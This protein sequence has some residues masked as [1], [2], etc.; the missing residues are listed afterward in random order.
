MDEEDLEKWTMGNWEDDIFILI[1]LGVIFGFIDNNAE[2]QE[3]EET[4]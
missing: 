4:D 1:L 2:T 3:I